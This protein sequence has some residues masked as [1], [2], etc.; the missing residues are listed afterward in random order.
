ME[1]SIKTSKLFAISVFCEVRQQPGTV[2]PK[3][4]P[5][6]KLSSLT[7]EDFERAVGTDGSITEDIGT[8]LK[9]LGCVVLNNHVQLLK[10]KTY[11]EFVRTIMRCIAA[12][13][14]YEKTSQLRVV[15]THRYESPHDHTTYD[16]TTRYVDLNCENQVIR[17]VVSLATNEQYPV[18]IRENV[19]SNLINDIT[20]DSIINSEARGLDPDSREFKKVVQEILLAKATDPSV[21]NGSDKVTQI[22][23]TLDDTTEIMK[24][25]IEKVMANSEDIEKLVEK[26][27]DLSD[28]SKFYFRKTKELNSCCRIL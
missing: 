3:K 15:N 1:E 26:S 22:K 8:D 18:R 7:L 19:L 23:G 17:F 27:K 2:A 16:I 21:A 28:V 5:F 24:Q 14:K 9:L 10:R 6:Q 25:N 11:S 20:R 4:N 13:Y 12:K